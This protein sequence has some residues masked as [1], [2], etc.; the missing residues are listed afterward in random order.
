MQ[1]KK[2]ELPKIGWLKGSKPKKPQAKKTPPSNKSQQKKSWLHRNLSSILIIM[3]GLAGVGLLVY[4]SFAD[5]WNSMHQ[6]YAIA[7]YDAAVAELDPH[8]YDEIMAA[9]EEYNAELAKTGVQ[10]TMTDAQ[11]KRY[12]SLLDVTG[13]GMMGYIDIPKIDV[14]LPIY[15]GTGDAVLQV[16]IGHIAGTSLPVGGKGTHVSVSGHCGLPSA[17]LFTDL[18]MMTVGDLFTITVLNREMTYEVDQIRIILPTQLDD[19]AIDPERDYVT[20]ITCTPY[21]INSHRLL[22]RGHRVGNGMSSVKVLAD[23]V[24]IRPYLVAI[25]LAVPILV[26][27]FVWLLFSTGHRVR[28]RRTKNRAT[29]EFRE[30]RSLREGKVAKDLS[31]GETADSMP[32]IAVAT[33]ADE[34]NADSADAVSSAETGADAHTDAETEAVARAGTDSDAIAKAGADAGAGVEAEAYDVE[35]AEAYDA[36]DATATNAPE[37]ATA[38]PTPDTPANADTPSEGE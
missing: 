2:R 1:F 3:M 36:P 17:R 25:L 16:A 38:E 31:E 9:A 23:A 30:R 8:E 14:S 28:H 32:G 35:L 33:S 11:L 34:A 10:W 12:N 19:L 21:G 37:P 24:Q 13:T 4:P 6:S 27:M 20:L 18:N 7:S 15:H 29:E 26:M 5:W 22:V